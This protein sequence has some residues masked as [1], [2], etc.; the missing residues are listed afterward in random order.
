MNHAET[1]DVIEKAESDDSDSLVTFSGASLNDGTYEGTADGYNSVITVSVD[2]QGGFV[3]DD[4]KVSYTYQYLSRT[5]TILI[6]FL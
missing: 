6:Y 2:V 5:E 1:V 4:Q 3:T